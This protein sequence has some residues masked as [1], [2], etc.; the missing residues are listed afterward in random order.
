MR[1]TGRTVGAIAVAGGLLAGA[2]LSA[3]PAAA[4]A[5]A[6]AEVTASINAYRVAQG[7]SALPPFATDGQVRQAHDH[8]VATGEM[9]T[10]FEQ[11]A[12]FY[13]DLGAAG[14][15][16]VESYVEGEGC[17]PEALLAQWVNSNYHRGLILSPDATH[18]TVSATCDGERAWATGHVLA[19]PVAPDAGEGS[20]DVAVPADDPTGTPDAEPVAPQ[21]SEDSVRAAPSATPASAPV[22]EATPEVEPDGNHAPAAAP[23]GA[24]PPAPGR[25]PS[26]APRVEGWSDQE[27]SGVEDVVDA[28]S[29]TPGG[30]ATA[31]ERPPD[32]G[33]QH[34]GPAAIPQAATSVSR[35][36]SAFS[37]DMGTTLLGGTGVTAFLVLAG[38]WRRRR[39]RLHGWKTLG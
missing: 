31:V 5:D 32:T 1:R 34:L 16:E 33:G 6:S 11:S 37:D 36:D 17:S 12:G 38:G 14:F 35:P 27:S 7:R 26:S 24:T 9:H 18:L 29:G 28:A 15:A 13:F 25:Q 19:F 2:L 21:A 39:R 30:L 22:T 4:V 23:G 10:L 20:E 3:G 8:L